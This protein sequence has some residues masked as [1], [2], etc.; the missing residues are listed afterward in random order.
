MATYPTA[1]PAGDAHGRRLARAALFTA[2]LAASSFAHP[3]IAHADYDPDY[4]RWCTDELKQGDSSCCRQAG[5]V[6]AGTCVDPATIYT[7]PPPTLN[8]SPVPGIIPP[9]AGV[10]P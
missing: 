5:G 8:R 2:A 6:F 9:G 7:P 10:T 4:F 1:S 3:V